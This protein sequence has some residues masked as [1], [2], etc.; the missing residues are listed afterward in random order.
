MKCDEE[1]LFLIALGPT[2]TVLAYD[3]TKYG[4]QAIDI[5]HFDI[6]YE[7]FLRGIKEDKVAIEGKYTNEVVGGDDVADIL[8]N[9]YKNEIITM[10]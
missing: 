2:A 1:V 6:E 3:L 8:D 10:V 4:Y 7:W 9:K 5:G